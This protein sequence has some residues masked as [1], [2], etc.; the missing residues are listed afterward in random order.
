MLPRASLRD[1]FSENGLHFVLA[2][3]PTQGCFRPRD[4]NFRHL[5]YKISHTEF[6]PTPTDES[7]PAQIHNLQC[8][9]M[10]HRWSPVDAVCKVPLANTGHLLGA[11][12]CSQTAVKQEPAQIRNGCA[13][14]TP[15]TQLQIY[16]TEHKTRQDN[17][18]N[19]SPITTHLYKAVVTATITNQHVLTCNTISSPQYNKDAIK[20]SD[21]VN[22]CHCL[23]LTSNPLTGKGS[24]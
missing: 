21:V 13:Q 18:S 8:Y 14:T 11:G 19:M 4:R 2:S 23:P 1:P 20:G 12:L 22:L 10:T 7:C 5:S 9:T 24:H 16:T 3:L 6:S 17:M 15:I